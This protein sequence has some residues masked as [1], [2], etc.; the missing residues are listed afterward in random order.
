MVQ[1]QTDLDDYPS[2]FWSNNEKANGWFGQI[3]STEFSLNFKCGKLNKT[4]IPRNET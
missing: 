3:Y 2:D 1:L 4:A